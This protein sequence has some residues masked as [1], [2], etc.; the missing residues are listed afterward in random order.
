MHDV[1][2]HYFSTKLS[3]DEVYGDVAPELFMDD[4]LGFRSYQYVHFHTEAVDNPTAHGNTKAKT[5]FI[6]CITR[7]WRAIAASDIMLSSVSEWAKFAQ[8]AIVMP[9][10]SVDN[11][12]VF[13]S[14]NFIKSALRSSL[15]GNHLNAAVHMFLQREYTIETFPFT[16]AFNDW[17]TPAGLPNSRGRYMV[18]K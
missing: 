2:P 9:I 10:G 5:V 12:R 15:K 18:N 8:L 6:P 7:M 11:E 17:S 4:E 14:M 3:T 16:K 13:S 1:A